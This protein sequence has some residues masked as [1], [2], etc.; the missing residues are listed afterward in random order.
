MQPRTSEGCALRSLCKY[1]RMM[2]Y[3]SELQVRRGSLTINAASAFAAAGSANKE[4]M[5]EAGVV[6]DHDGV[7]RVVA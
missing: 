4:A 3:Y 2:H 6:A 7:L 5:A 1:G